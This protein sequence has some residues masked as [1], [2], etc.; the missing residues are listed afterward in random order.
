MSR[1]LISRTVGE[2]MRCSACKH[3]IDIGDTVDVVC[4]TDRFVEIAFA[5]DHEG[6]GAAFSAWINHNGG[7]ADSE[8]NPVDLTVPKP[9][10]HTGK[11]GGAK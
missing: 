11:K 7:W 1:E 5:C 10:P 8:G 4:V 9:G 2:N 3:P 6:C